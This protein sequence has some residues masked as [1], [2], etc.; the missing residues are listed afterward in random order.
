M[1]LHLICVKY[2]L[3]GDYLLRAGHTDE[4]IALTCLDEGF[5]VH[6]RRSI[7]DTAITHKVIQPDAGGALADA[8]KAYGKRRAKQGAPRPINTTLRGLQPCRAKAIFQPDK[9]MPIFHIRRMETSSSA[10]LIFA[11][12]WR[13]AIKGVLAGEGYEVPD[14]QRRWSLRYIDLPLPATPSQELQAFIEAVDKKKG[15]K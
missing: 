6:G 4:A 3:Q 12:N 11:D 2:I 15:V 8:I 5:L 1:P 9:T 10:F 7:I 13:E 14:L